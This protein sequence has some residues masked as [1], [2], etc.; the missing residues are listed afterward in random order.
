M[1]KI[2]DLCVWDELK[3]I[4]FNGGIWHRGTIQHVE[5]LKIAI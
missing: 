1:T 4:Q 2:Y 3:L 5:D